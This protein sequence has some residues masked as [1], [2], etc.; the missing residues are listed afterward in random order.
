[1]DDVNT[2]VYDTIDSPVQE[3]YMLTTVDNPYNPFTEWESWFAFDE[4][5]GYHTNGLLA[6]MALTSNELTDEEN[7]M[8]ISHA[9]DDILELF[10]G[11]YR[12]VS[13]T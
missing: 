10:P 11:L 1:M 3:E 7:E 9:V 4:Q 6:R 5:N 8:A 12:K 2:T 13:K